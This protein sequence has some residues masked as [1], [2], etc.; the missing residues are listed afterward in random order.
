MKTHSYAYNTTYPGPAFPVVDL[1]I[2]GQNSRQEHVTALVD[3]GADGTLIPLTIL[4]RIS[5]R[6]I[7]GRWA[8]NISGIRY[9]VSMF[10]VDLS[11]GSYVF[12]STEVIANQQTDE[13]VV[14]RDVLNQ[15]ILVLNGLAY[16]V[17]VS[18]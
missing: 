4:Q 2:T 12:P 6:K 16:V 5:A 14:G 11:I 17:E 7:D 10:M 1:R 8:R 15:L 3:S 9:R 18:M 13:I